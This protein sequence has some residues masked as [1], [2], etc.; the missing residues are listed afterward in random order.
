[1]WIIESLNA[2]KGYDQMLREMLAADELSPN[3]PASLRATG[4]LVRNFKMLSREKWLQ[5]TVD[6][7]FL[8]FQAVTVGCAKCHDHMYDPIS[9]KKFSKPGAIFTPH[10]GRIDRLPGEPDTKKD[11]LARAFDA[12]LAAQTFLLIRGDDRM[13]DKS[14][15]P[16]GVPASLGGSY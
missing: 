7:T 4:F 10:Q 15:L 11:G 9:Q 5:D 16:P 6:H 14:P 12:D 13:P 2:D 1:D 3:D 8:A